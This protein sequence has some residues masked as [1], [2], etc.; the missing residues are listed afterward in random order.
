MLAGA[1]VKILCRS[2]GALAIAAVAL[3][4]SSCSAGGDASPEIVDSETIASAAPV[5]SLLISPGQVWGRGRGVHAVQASNGSS[6]VVTTTGVYK[7][8]AD[9]ADPFEIG[10]FDFGVRVADAALAPDE[11]ALAV[12]L[13]QPPSVQIYDLLGSEPVRTYA[14]PAAAEVHA[15][16]FVGTTGELVVDTSI[17]PLRL[18]ESDAS[19]IPVLENVSASGLTA[20]LSSGTSVTPIE[21]TA[22]LVLGRLDGNERRTLPLDQ[23]STVLDARASPDGTV[24]AVSIAGGDDQFE[25]SDKIVVFDATTMETRGVIETDRVIDPSQW[26]VIRD[27]VVLSDGA[28]VAVFTFDGTEEGISTVVESPVVSLHAL[29][30]RA[31]A[32]HANGAVT[33]WSGP[34]ASSTVLDPGGIALNSV[35]LSPDGQLLTTVNYY[36]LVTTWNMA[37]GARVSSDERFATGEATSVAISRD[38]GHVGVVSSSGR[39]SVL[40]DELR[41]EWTFQLTEV[42]AYVGSVSFDPSSGAIAT[43]LADRLGETSFDDAVT[44][45]DPGLRSAMFSVGGEG[46]EVQGCSLFVSRIR[47]D[48][49]NHRMAIT[50]HDFSVLIVDN[51]TGQLIHEIPGKAPILDVAFSPSGGLLV[52]TYDDAT[53]DVWDMTSL[54]VV[55]SYRGTQGGYLAIA[56]LPDNATMVAADILGSI[57]VVDIMTGTPLTVFADSSFRTT[58]LALSSDGALLAAPTADAGI[59][60]WSVPDGRRVATIN[61]H[62]A[63]TTGLAFSPEGDWLASTSR[64]GTARTWTLDEV[65]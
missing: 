18:T 29:D 64:D 13:T 17:G 31:L 38:G 24:L 7:I 3:V 20:I 51:T 37:D 57:S 44:V 46:E 55:A 36:G 10:R 43:G 59:G 6:T 42:P 9:G 35:H 23:G 26:V 5:Q 33:S 27:G 30:E 53:V 62:T 60:V 65:D 52:V 22:D 54:S 28:E 39:V 11:T 1:D 63:E 14:L 40:D 15:I 32:V 19:P 12:V 34:L 56:M 50:S 49:A 25:R 45:W 2:L 41:D 16:Q 4:S 47:Y 61:G 58:T 21:G 48:D 8:P